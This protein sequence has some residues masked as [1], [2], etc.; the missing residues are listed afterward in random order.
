M[1]FFTVPTITFDCCFVISHDRQ[2]ILHESPSPESS[3]CTESIIVFTPTLPRTAR[4]GPWLKFWRTT[5]RSQT[6]RA[7]S[8]RINWL[9][10]A[11]STLRSFATTEQLSGSL[12]N[13][14]TANET[15]PNTRSEGALGGRRLGIH[16]L[17]DYGEKDFSTRSTIFSRR[18]Q[19]RRSQLRSYAPVIFSL[20]YNLGT[21]SPDTCMGYGASP[22]RA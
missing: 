18:Q 20:A 7:A 1:D 19:R 2:R 3:C 11:I 21:C 5:P 12:E 16:L 10:A 13:L 14:G 22:Q 8:E 4:F 9:W 17:Q 6:S 15:S